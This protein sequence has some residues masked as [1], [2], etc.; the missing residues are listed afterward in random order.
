M[1]P[2]SS[3]DQYKAFRSLDTSRGAAKLVDLSEYILRD[4]D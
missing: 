2:G 4:C 3:I 1:N